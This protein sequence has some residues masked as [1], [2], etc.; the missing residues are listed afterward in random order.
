MNLKSIYI[1]SAL[2]MIGII[3]IPGC[4]KKTLPPDQINDPVFFMDMGIN[5]VHKTFTAG[6]NSYYMF[7]DYEMD[8]SGL[9]FFS[10]KFKRQ[11]C[12][13]CDEELTIIITDDTVRSP[14]G[15][16]VDI[17]NSVLVG[18]YQY[19]MNRINQGNGQF[20]RFWSQMKGG[21]P[22]TF[23]WNFGDESGSSFPN[24]IHYFS[25]K[26]PYP[27]PVTLNTEDQFG[28][29]G[30]AYNL[31]DLRMALNNCRADFTYQ[32]IAPNQLRVDA[33]SVTLPGIQYFWDNPDSVIVTGGRSAILTFPANGV[34]MV[35]LRVTDGDCIETR[36]KNIP[37]PANLTDCVTNFNYEILNDLNQLIF[38]KAIVEWKDI[39]GKLYSSNAVVEQPQS[40]Y[41]EILEI[42]D[43]D[44]NENGDATVKLKISMNCVLYNINNPSDQLVLENAKGE[45]AIAYP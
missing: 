4:K 6:L 19:A 17:R 45:I 32:H 30:L 25:T 33:D 9:Y 14:S 42:S 35:C 38:S 24:P 41:F 20:V 3:L 29:K 13:D 8:S 26:G 23:N 31:I 1:L 2:L 34:Q 10:G 18:P 11:D 15:V 28:C 37:I 12:N 5:G 40:S 39:N 21:G 16:S 36:C 22:F 27:F 44:N 43:Y 7:S